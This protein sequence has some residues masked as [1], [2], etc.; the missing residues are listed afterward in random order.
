[1]NSKIAS[2]YNKLFAEF[3]KEYRFMFS[4]Y[5]R[6]FKAGSYSLILSDG[7]TYK[8]NT[9]VKDRRCVDGMRFKNIFTTTD[10]NEMRKYLTEHTPEF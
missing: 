9:L 8:L 10:V 2:E 6:G 3:E 1:M 5:S 7:K 4:N